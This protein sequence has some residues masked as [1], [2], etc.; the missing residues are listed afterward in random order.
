MADQKDPLAVERLFFASLLSSNAD[1][2]DQALA[3]DFLIIDV[4]SGSET[5]KAALLDAI[6]A[7]LL[8]FEK[9]ECLET[10]VRNYDKTAVITGRTRMSGRF[11][12]TAFSVSSRYTHVYV[13]L[14]GRWR[15]ASAQGTPISPD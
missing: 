3:D 7:G 12:E 2:L 5:P 10:R 14:Q 1:A 15:M 6:R 9:I 13:E 11:G 8:K 4:M